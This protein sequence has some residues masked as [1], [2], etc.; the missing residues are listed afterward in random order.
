MTKTMAQRRAEA[1]ERIKGLSP[2]ELALGPDIDDMPLE[3]DLEP[4]RDEDQEDDQ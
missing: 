2:E 1:A 3:D 4:M